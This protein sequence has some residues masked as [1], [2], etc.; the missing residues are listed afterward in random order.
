MM[1]KDKQT[2]KK[3]VNE[4]VGRSKGRQHNQVRSKREGE[5]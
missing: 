1:I 2:G 5:E 4:R 3:R